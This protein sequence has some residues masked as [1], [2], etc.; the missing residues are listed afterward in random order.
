MHKDLKRSTWHRRR[1]WRCGWRRRKRAAHGRAIQPDAFVDPVDGLAID[2]ARE[3]LSHRTI[4]T[5]TAEHIEGVL[6]QGRLMPKAC[7]RE[8]AHHSPSRRSSVVKRA[9]LLS[10][11]IGERSGV[12]E[13]S[14]CDWRRVHVARSAVRIQ[15]KRVV[16]R[17]Q[18]KIRRYQVWEAKLSKEAPPRRVP[19]IYS[20]AFG[21]ISFAIRGATSQNRARFAA[22]ASNGASNS[23][24]I[25]SPAC[26][27]RF[28]AS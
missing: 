23:P 14:S 22:L 8:A 10:C 16:L 13:L 12:F 11:L 4:P 26:R 18:Q 5:P 21:T 27:Q 20:S 17:G 3:G 9:D 7:P 2:E 28:G 19:T 1:C 25:C 6:C 15:T 24:S